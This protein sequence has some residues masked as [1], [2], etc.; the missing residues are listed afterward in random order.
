MSRRLPSSPPTSPPPSPPAAPISPSSEKTTSFAR[1][2]SAEQLFGPGFARSP[3]A[4]R[5]A[6]FIARS[7]SA[8]RALDLFHRGV[9]GVRQR[10][11]DLRQRARNV[12]NVH[13]FDIPNHM[14]GPF[15]LT[16]YRANYDLR[17]CIRSLWESH[18]ETVN[19][20]LHVLGCFI[21]LAI[22]WYVATAEADLPPA[23]A[24]L[25]R[26]PLVVFVLSALGCLGTSALYH[27]VGTANEKYFDPLSQVDYI[28]IVG[29]IVGSCFP[30]AWY[31]FTPIYSVTRVLYLTAICSTGGLVIFGSLTGALNRWSDVTRIGIFVALA[32]S[33]FFALLHAVVVHEFSERT[34]ALLRGVILMG[35]IYFAGIG[36]Y[37]T[38]FTE[39]VAPRSLFDRFGASH[40]YWHACV[41]LAAYVHF[42]TVFSLYC[43]TALFEAAQGLVNPSI[44]AAVE[45]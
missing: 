33:G 14:R 39:S 43:E 16:S 4:E 44:A 42:R 31:G 30:V 45:L 9:D 37:V 6:A 17:A 3:S 11:D 29:L 35:G 41:L 26:W 8:E 5:V 21:F 38:S 19:V 32:L 27:L 34:T 1:S 13:I 15:I 7:P 25:E 23:T 18:N 12:K 36:F 2:P 10:A 40:Q 28:G 24:N 22:L 20:W